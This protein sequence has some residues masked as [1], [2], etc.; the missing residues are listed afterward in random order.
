M[1]M[2]IGD[3]IYA[4]PTLVMAMALVFAYRRGLNSIVIMVI[5]LGWPT[6]TRV[7]HSEILEIRNSDYIMAARASG[8]S[9][10]RILRTHVLPNSIFS[11]IIVASMNVGVTILTV[12]AL[13]FLGLGS[14]T[15]YAGWGAIF[16]GSSPRSATGPR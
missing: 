12:A 3:I 6:Y 11:L 14:D 2:R 5:I 7:I 9:H 16:S 15:G 13:S 1:I 4:I 10:A 8:A